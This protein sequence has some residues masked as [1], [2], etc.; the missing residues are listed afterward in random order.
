MGSV[1]DPSLGALVR[2]MPK[3]MDEAPKGVTG[4]PVFESD[5]GRVWPQTLEAKKTEVLSALQE[6][7]NDFSNQ[8]ES[9]ALVRAAMTSIAAILAPKALLFVALL[10]ALGLTI[11]ALIAADWHQLL[12]AVSFDVL[13]F[14]PTAFL[15]WKGEHAQTP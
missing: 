6:K 8:M 12:A 13:V 2:I 11:P 3:D 4:V 5:D 15:Y 10:G 1:E 7:T 14:W 9:L